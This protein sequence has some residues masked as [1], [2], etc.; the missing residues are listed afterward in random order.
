M[1][2]FS[3]PD[4]AA[5]SYTVAFALAFLT[6]SS[7]DRSVWSTNLN[8]NGGLEIDFAIPRESGERL[9]E[10]DPPVLLLGEAKT[11]GRFDRRDFR[12]LRRLRRLFP[13]AILVVATFR[14][15]LTR[16]ERTAL[17]EIA[18]PDVKRFSQVR[19]DPPMMVLTALEL[20]SGRNAPDCWTHAGGRAA[21]IAA[22]NT[23]IAN[24]PEVR[25]LADLTAQIHLRLPAQHEWARRTSQRLARRK[26]RKR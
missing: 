25:R 20:L 14:S 23:T 11:D 6:Q 24:L 5:G 3:F 8:L 9:T 13:E 4:Y 10:G 17:R 18:Q 12:R 16:D 1:G 22:Q 19:W 2:A 21:E 15:E 26:Q 7:A